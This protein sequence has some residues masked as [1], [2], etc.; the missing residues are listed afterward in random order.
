MR[1][2]TSE[3]KWKFKI[4]DKQIRLLSWLW[5]LIWEN[6]ISNF[7]K[8]QK[9]KDRSFMP[10]KEPKLTQNTNSMKETMQPHH[11]SIQSCWGH[12]KG[13]NLKQIWLMSQFRI[14]LLEEIT[15]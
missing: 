12:F 2:E 6:L 11:S 8:I 15:H 5:I 9:L 3:K 7:K 14:W 10:L 4:Y 1:H 13:Q